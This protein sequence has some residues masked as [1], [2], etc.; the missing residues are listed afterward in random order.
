MFSAV[1]RCRRSIPR[2][3]S[4][5]AVSPP[6]RRDGRTRLSLHASLLHIG[7]NLW[8]LFDLGPQVESLFST[9]KFIVMYLTTG[10][11]GFIFSLVWSPFVL[12]VG[13]SGAIL[14]LIGAL[15]SASY[16]HGQLGAAYRGMLIRWL[17]YIAIFG[18]FFAADNAAH[19]GGLA[20]GALLG[21]LIPEGEAATRTSERAWDTL[22]LLCVLIIAASFALM[23][24]Q[25]NR[26]LG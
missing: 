9:P 25:L 12:S 7:M 22:A 17:I 8:C 11:V 10:V 2:N 1:A 20:T 24:L 6:L 14:G 5:S 4:P 19:L 13:A 26:P 15:I 3:R 21:Y 16:R 18:F 23:A